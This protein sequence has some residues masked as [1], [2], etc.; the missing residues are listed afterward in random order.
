[1]NTFMAISGWVVAASVFLWYRMNRVIVFTVQ[2]EEAK[3]CENCAC[4]GSCSGD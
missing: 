4:G 2:V 3:Q 1:M